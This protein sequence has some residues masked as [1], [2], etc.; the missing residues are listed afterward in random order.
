MGNTWSIG[1]FKE[2][3]D[4]LH[5]VNN[6]P[7]NLISTFLGRNLRTSSR[8]IHTYA[9][10]FLYEEKGDLYLFAE[11]QAVRESGYI[12]CWKYT[13][14]EKWEDIGPILKETNRYTYPFILKDKDELY[15]IPESLEAGEVSL[16]KFHNFPKD[17]KKV[18]TIL[19]GPYVDS[20]VICYNNK[21]Y[22]FTTTNPAG[23][24]LIF[25]SDELLSDEWIPHPS[26]PITRNKQISRNGGGVV[27]YGNRLVRIAQDDANGYGKGIVI[28]DILKLD[29][30]QYEEAI[31]IDDFKPSRNYSWQQLGRHHLS[32][33][34]FR[35]SVFIAMDGSAK[36]IIINKLINGFFKFLK[37]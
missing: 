14:D 5:E 4:F 9:D 32:V 25:F 33:C 29:E 30:F 35:E 26:N 8:H 1:I 12:N 34:N 17:L 2:K 11:I 13:D 24:L 27:M 7:V 21:Y 37:R 31:S 28:L 6:R 22:L 10:P 18:K 36:D 15:M 3:N 19:K 20:N 16:W 23:E